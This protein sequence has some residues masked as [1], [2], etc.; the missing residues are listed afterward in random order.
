RHEAFGVEEDFGST[1]RG[2]NRDLPQI[3]ALFRETLWVENG[4]VFGTQAGNSAFAFAPRGGNYKDEVGENQNHC[5]RAAPQS[6]NG[7]HGGG[8]DWR[9]C[10][11]SG[12]LSDR[13]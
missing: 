6:K 10:F 7:D 12:A 9:N 4:F 1:C 3:M 5:C 8:P 11:G 13:R 2:T